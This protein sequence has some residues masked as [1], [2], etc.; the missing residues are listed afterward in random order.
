[1]TRYTPKEFQ[2]LVHGIA[3]GYGCI[4]VVCHIG[5]KIIIEVGGEK[6]P[7]R[8][9]VLDFDRAGVMK[10]V[11]Y[12]VNLHCAVFTRDYLA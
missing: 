11:R 3:H 6:F 2:D 5:D 10:I 1:M 8:D 9:K 4:E 12:L 7:L